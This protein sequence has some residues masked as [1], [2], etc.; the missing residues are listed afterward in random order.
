MTGTLSG[1]LTVRWDRKWEFGASG[2]IVSENLRSE[3]V[4]EGESD[5]EWEFSVESDSELGFDDEGDNE[6]DFDSEWDSMG[7]SNW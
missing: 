3:L 7:T 1:D 6:L 2:R 5:T 4:F